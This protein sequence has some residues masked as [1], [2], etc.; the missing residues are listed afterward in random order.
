MQQRA[1]RASE[2]E[3]SDTPTYSGPMHPTPK[4]ITSKSAQEFRRSSAKVKEQVVRALAADEE[5]SLQADTDAIF[6][7]SKPV[8]EQGSTV[9]FDRLHSLELSVLQDVHRPNDAASPTGTELARSEPGPSQG[10]AVHSLPSAGMHKNTRRISRE[11]QGVRVQNHPVHTSNQDRLAVDEQ[12]AHQS[13]KGRPREEASEEQGHGAVSL[14]RSRSR[15]HEQGSRLAATSHDEL[16]RAGPPPRAATGRARHAAQGLE[17]S[18]RASEPVP[19]ALASSAGDVLPHQTG[20]V[21]TS[22]AAVKAAL[23]R[24]RQKMRLGDVKRRALEFVEALDRIPT[25]S[26]ARAPRPGVDD[27]DDAD[28]GGR[29][30]DGA[31]GADGAEQGRSTADKTAFR[32]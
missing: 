26:V 21:A 17:S 8:D 18:H 28:K 16:P 12:G 20:R 27:S 24:L 23:E 11:N 29:S 19:P 3:G 5:A 6:G 2:H 1:S 32:V 31:H 4:P 15:A 30:A 7:D 13:S 25:R 22:S 14:S 10:S 9:G